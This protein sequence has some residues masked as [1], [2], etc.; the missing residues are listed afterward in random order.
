MNCFAVN[1][2]RIDT[3]SNGLLE[4]LLEA[5]IAP[6][7]ANLR[8][9]TVVRQ[10]LIEPVTGKPANRKIDLRFTHE[11]AVVNNALKE[12]RQHQTNRCFGSNTGAPIV[13]TVQILDFV[14]EPGQI[15]N[16]VN[17]LENMVVWLRTR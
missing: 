3:A 2:A 14:P 7:L 17:L 16:S 13:T 10:L 15:E 12:S 5:F 6:T 4:N 8:K 11:L 9:R 1:Q